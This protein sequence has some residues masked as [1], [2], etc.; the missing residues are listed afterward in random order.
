MY[1]GQLTKKKKKI[2][3]SRK[4]H[5]ILISLNISIFKSY[6]FPKLTELREYL[7]LFVWILLDFFFFWRVVLFYC[8]ILSKQLGPGS[9]FQYLWPDLC[10][11]YNSAPQGREADIQDRE[12]WRLSRQK[13]QVTGVHLRYPALSTLSFV[14]S[15]TLSASPAN[16]LKGQHTNLVFYFS[17]KYFITLWLF[18]KILFVRLFVCFVALPVALIIKYLQVMTC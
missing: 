2:P 8:S 9:K 1:L 15:T 6:C 18:V 4:R 7:C 11:V 16:C 12:V 3:C 13:L 14:M 17:Q 5:A 10:C